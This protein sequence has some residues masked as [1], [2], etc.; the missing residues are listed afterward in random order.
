M[1]GIVPYAAN[2]FVLPELLV[3]PH[4]IMKTILYIAKDIQQQLCKL[5]CSQEKI[6]QQV[7]RSSRRRANAASDFIIVDGF[8][9]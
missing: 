4:R 6:V 9:L 5:L 7:H 8:F 2:A 3:G 1:N